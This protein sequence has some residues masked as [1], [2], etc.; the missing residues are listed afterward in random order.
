MKI[1]L[2]Q[3]TKPTLYGRW[4]N[5]QTVGGDHLDRVTGGWEFHTDGYYNVLPKAGIGN[6][7]KQ[8]EAG[9]YFTPSDL[10]AE[11]L[12]THTHGTQGCV[13]KFQ[14]TPSITTRAIECL[15]KLG[16][17]IVIQKQTVTITTHI[18]IEEMSYSPIFRQNNLVTENSTNT[19]VRTY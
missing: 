18:L 15:R 14:N 12:L 2:I 19:V 13:Y 3:P 9:F 10:D 7:W 6:K 4:Y 1:K 17:D 8:D 16:Y 11:Y 5:E